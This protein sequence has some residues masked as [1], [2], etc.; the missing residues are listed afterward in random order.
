MPEAT[1]EVRRLEAAVSAL[2]EGNMHA[3][4]LLRAL[5]VARAR[6]QTAPLDK[7]IESCKSFLERDRKRAGRLEEVISR[8][9]TEKEASTGNSGE[10][11]PFLPT[12]VDA[13]VDALVGLL[14]EQIEG[15]QKERDVLLA[16]AT[17]VL[18][19]SAPVWMGDGPPSLTILRC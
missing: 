19:R 15:L 11:T 3:K 5:E 8:G 1:E 14:Q 2:G 17:P 18:P 7:R 10:R 6:S 13:Q 4:P 9:T 16:A 12:E